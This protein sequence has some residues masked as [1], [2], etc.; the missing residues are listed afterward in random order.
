MTSRNPLRATVFVVGS[1]VADYMTLR[2]MAADG[3]GEVR[4]F[5]GGRDVLRLGEHSPPDLWIVNVRLPDISGFDLVEMLQ[6][7]RAGSVLLMMADQY[8]AADE[9]RALS[10]GVDQYSCKP[11]E[12]AYLRQ[13]HP[14]ERLA[15]RPNNSGSD[16][17][18]A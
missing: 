6:P 14:S 18:E 10:L 5:A 11:L 1:N 9:I 16:Y 17:G 8:H 4:V 2:Q 12:A 13:W 15:Q 7:R 3:P